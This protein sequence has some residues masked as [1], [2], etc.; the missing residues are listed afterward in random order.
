MSNQ[1]LLLKPRGAGRPKTIQ[2]PGT[3]VTTW[4]PTAVHDELIRRAQQRSDRS[5]SAVTRDLLR[6]GTG[7]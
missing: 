5:V 7:R 1:P 3:R 6:R 2:G 4:V